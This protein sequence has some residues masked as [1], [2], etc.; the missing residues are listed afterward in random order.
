MTIDEIINKID[1]IIKKENITEYV[2]IV[3]TGGEPMMIK[4][5]IINLTKAI[6]DYMEQNML[7]S[8]TTI[9]SNGTFFR[10]EILK[11]VDLFSLSPKLKSSVPVG[12]EFEHLHNTNRINRESFKQ[13]S[14]LSI[15]SDAPYDVQWK[16]VISREE[17]IDEILK[18]KNDYDIS[19]DHIYFMPMGS[20]KEELE[21]TRL[22]T[23]NLALKYH[24]NFTDRVH[25]SIF[26]NKRGV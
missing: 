13:F 24:V 11:Y 6:K 20:T 22:L 23:W 15:R 1:E 18:M 4:D 7:S 16:F 25:I 3:I 8:K 19:F 21:K 5:D 10:E 26:D 17:D 14:S 2:D 12:T 9:E